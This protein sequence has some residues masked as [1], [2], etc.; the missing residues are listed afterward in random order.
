M[1]NLKL[2]INNTEISNSD[3]LEKI[4]FTTKTTSTD[5]SVGD[6]IFTIAKTKFRSTV[7]IGYGD[8]VKIT[9]IDEDNN[10]IPYGTY[11]P[12]E[13]KKNEFSKDVEL[14][15]EPVLRLMETYVPTLTNYS[16]R[17]L[18]LEMMLS[19]G[20]EVKELENVLSVDLDGTEEDWSKARTGLEYLSYI[21]CCIRKNV[22]INR[23]NQVEFKLFTETDYMLNKSQATS[24]TQNEGSYFITGVEIQG[25]NSDK[26]T[27][28]NATNKAGLISIK[29]PFIKS[30]AVASNI[31]SILSTVP[32]YEPLKLKYFQFSPLINILDMITVE[33]KDG[34]TKTI[35]IMNL[36]VTYSSGGLV[37]EVESTISNTNTKGGGYTGTISSR[38]EIINNITREL[39]TK[40]TVIDGNISTVITQTDAT[41][42]EITDK[43]S[44]I[45]QTV[46]GITMKVEEMKK[47]GGTN[48]IGQ[49][50][51]TQGYEAEV[52]EV[53]ET[54]WTVRGSNTD[55]DNAVFRFV[56]VLDRNGWYTFS[57]DGKFGGSS[58][59]TYIQ[60]NDQ[61]VGTVDLTSEWQHFSFTFEV[62]NYDFDNT[63]VY[64]FIE[65]QRLGNE[66]YYFK[67]VQLEHG[68]IETD[69]SPC[70]N[71]YP[72]TTQMNSAI[73]QT[74]TEISLTVAREEVQNMEVGGTNLLGS[75]I[76]IFGL[77]KITS[78]VRTDTTSFEAIGHVDNDGTVWIS[79]IIDGN[80]W[81]TISF[82]V[83]CQYD[84]WNVDVDFC[85]GET[86]RFNNIST[87]DY[88]HC[89]Y[90]YEVTNYTSDV[91]H[92]IEFCGLAS[93]TFWFKN[94]K[95]ERGKI[96]TDYSPCPRDYPTT[97][98][99][100]SAIIQKADSITS[101]VNANY[102]TLNNKFNDYPTT[103]QMNSAITQKAN[104]ITSAV[105]ETKRVGVELLP[106]MYK[107]TNNS[108]YKTVSGKIMASQYG[109]YCTERTFMVSDYIELDRTVPVHLYAWVQ[110]NLL[111]GG[112]YGTV[113]VGLEQFDINKTEVAEDAATLYIFQ[114]TAQYNNYA[115]E[116]IDI[117]RFHANT[118]YIR[119]RILMNWNSASGQGE[120]FVR[121]VSIKQLKGSGSASLI[122]QKTDSITSTVSSLSN[123]VKTAESTITQ[124]A[125]QIATKVDV[126][127]VKSTIQQNPESVRIGFN[128]ISNYFDLNSTRL[129][130][131]HSDGSY[132]QI[133]Q[134]GVTY[135]AN[136]SGNRYHNLMKQ[137][138]LGQISGT[139][140][141]RT[142]T[143][144]SEFKGKTFSIIISITE[145]NAVNTHDVIKHFKITVPQNTVNYNNGTFVINASALAYYV[146]GQQS[147]SAIQMDVSWIAIA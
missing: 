113:Y 100:N 59:R 111:S 85:H 3:I 55:R 137:G 49:T 110:Y 96:A 108:G 26:I 4:T 60:A 51:E 133:G 127:G 131:G 75:H 77:N 115:D 54:G 11:L 18:L 79:N 12:Y 98:Q 70:F 145:V 116:A 42:K 94:I 65:F 72:T 56:N 44:S 135:Y 63:G 109:M 134:N 37:A 21:G 58:F 93:Q 67:N 64:T 69:Y 38:L 122:Q 32:T 101:T 48:L 19:L 71:D 1:L 91:Y 102:T 117:S 138:W 112:S 16:T 7:N 9:I 83:K 74:A 50:T 25:D 90:S 107:N 136:G 68:K 126:N 141:S 34:T 40:V 45:D 8:V 106:Q 53:T 95:V 66:L 17:S 86:K 27:V 80:G 41:L 84:G 78:F 6:F 22:V 89:V 20:F 118:R 121:E 10:E 139:S 123:R 143:L 125:N 46:S 132:T 104:E 99:M 24:L 29:N 103:T 114:T 73:T 43:Q 52:V 147:A 120:V 14:Y 2:T 87:T 28:G 92:F 129:Q 128:G 119:L 33:L 61:K 47:I 142:I 146:P 144:P 57:F 140:W 35:P 82:D 39:N 5:L 97:T 62:T 23:H 88:T 15:S 130:V 36:V 31:L 30:E 105:N 124:H 76:P 81:Y 13:I